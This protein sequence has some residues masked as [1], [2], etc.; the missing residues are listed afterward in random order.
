MAKFHALRLFTN[1]N[2]QS[3]VVYKIPSCSENSYIGETRNR[4]GTRTGQHEYKIEVK[5]RNHSALCA[6]NFGQADILF[7]IERNHKARQIKR[8]LYL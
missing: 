7:M 6:P 8:L 1:V 3:H 4:L 2:K 5:N